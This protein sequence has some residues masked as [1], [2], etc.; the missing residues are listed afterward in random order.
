MVV[1]ETKILKKIEYANSCSGASR[2]VRDRVE[3]D[4]GKKI[5]D[6]IV[7]LNRPD[8]KQIAALVQTKTVAV[9]LK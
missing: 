2:Y 4:H 1:A 5:L 7:S 9:F 3:K 8:G 6:K